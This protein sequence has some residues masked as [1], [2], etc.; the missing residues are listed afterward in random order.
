MN[1]LIIDNRLIPSAERQLA[2]FER[3]VKEIKKAEDELKAAI[4]AEMEA[5]G[6][7]KLEGDEM[8]ITYI[9]PTD[10][11]KFD[12]ARFRKEHPDL[13]DEYIRMTPVAGYI[14]IA[15]KEAQE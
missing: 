4:K 14:K 12:K 5:R 1:E 9:A 15:L 7:R 13:H 3:M 6:I 10:T 8:A 2:H 11:E